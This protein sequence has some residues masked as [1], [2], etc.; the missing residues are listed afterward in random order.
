M[1]STETIPTSAAPVNKGKGRKIAILG[2]FVATFV[3]G[4]AIGSAGGGSSN[5]AAPA[6]TP[7][8]VSAPAPA[9]IT[10]TASAADA[11]APVTVTETITVAPAPAAAPAAAAPAAPAT[12]PADQHKNGK[13]L[14]G[15][16]IESGTWQCAESKTIGTGSNQLDMAYWEVTAQNNDIVENGNDTIAVIGDEGYTVTLSGCATNWVKA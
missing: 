14:L 9:P 11:P 10:V 1:T 15:S 12:G 8:T 5:A 2:G 7:V 13:F 16:Q 3:I 4:I 6:P